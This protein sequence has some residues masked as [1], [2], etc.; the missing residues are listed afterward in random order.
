MPW[1]VAAEWSPESW[2][3]K[4]AAHQAVYPDRGSVESAVS[5]LRSLPPLVTS[6][7]IERL[8]SHIAE[9]QEGRR[10]LLQGGDCAE[11]LAECR[12]DIIASKLKILLQMSLVLV[13]GLKK[14][15]I[16]VGRFAGQYA[17]PRS[18]PTETRGG[19]TLPSYF[20]DLV[21]GAEFTAESRRADPERMVLGYQ[22][23]A[24]TLN[25]IRSLIDGGFAD[26]HHP[27][28]WDLRFME[29][30]HLG[31]E[32]RESYQRMTRELAEALRFMEVLGET[33]VDE[34]TR[35]EFFTSHEG[36]NLLYESA[37]TRG[38]PRRAGAFNLTTHFPWIGERTRAIEGAHVEFFRGIRNPIGVKI[39]PGC[40]P[41]ELLQ[42][43]ET[44]NPLNEPG[45]MVLIHRMGAGRIEESLPGLLTAVR[46]ASLRSSA[47]GGGANGAGRPRVLW[48]CDPM[49]GNMVTTASGIK[50]R[51]FSDIIREI[52]LAA[53]LHRR[54]GTILGG[55]HFELTG[56]D[57]TECVGGATG[58][59][60]ADLSVNYGSLCDPRL[61]YQQA[62]EMAFAIARML[63]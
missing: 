55:V 11:T 51:N 54:C 53:A 9:A 1:Q 21:N 26:L 48:V 17:K 33:S 59:S 36:L 62:M 13:H 46:D 35:V 7:E 31:D 22:H 47:A 58:V 57:V 27:E 29:H 3:S 16:R 10:F 49:H 12:P 45:R 18:S 44:L 50:T 5:K 19:V 34:L 40:K 42:L 24:L 52:E 60:E 39:G 15:V 61:N 2:K 43:V 20:G 25:F 37:Q 38:V 30:A 28:Y 63:G 6:G 32:L 4:L 14:P 56:E 41:A 23:A 8:R